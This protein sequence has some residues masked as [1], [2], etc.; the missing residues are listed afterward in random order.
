[1][2]TCSTLE[3]KAVV[4][5]TQHPNRFHDIFVCLSR[6]ELCYGLCDVVLPVLS[7]HARH[8]GHAASAILV[9]VLAAPAIA[10]KVID[11]LQ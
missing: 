4:E 8:A 5:A 1:M 10:L 2:S 11:G 9:A 3:S 6:I 7:I